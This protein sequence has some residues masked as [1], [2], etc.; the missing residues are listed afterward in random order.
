MSFLEEGSRRNGRSA[1]CIPMPCPCIPIAR[2][3]LDRD[4]NRAKSL[5]SSTLHIASVDDHDAY[6]EIPT[7]IIRRGLF[8]WAQARRKKEERDSGDYWPGDGSSSF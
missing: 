1:A 7:T 2:F 6:P 5:V 4:S 8:L 3:L